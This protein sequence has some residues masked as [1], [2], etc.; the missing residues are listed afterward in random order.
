V[1]VRPIRNIAGHVEFCEVFFDRARTHRSNIVGELNEGWAVSRAVLGFERLRVGAPRI[2][3]RF[4][5]RLIEIARRQD[6]TRDPLFRNKLTQLICDVRD[7]ASLFEKVA[8]AAK[9]GAAPGPEASALKLLATDT[10]QQVSQALVEVLGDAGVLSGVQDFNGYA[11]EALT[12]FLLTR[13]V[14]IYGGTSEVQR[15]IIAKRIL[16]M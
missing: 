7:L 12:P 4:L 16:G 9:T 15:N 6:L 1:T 10:E 8:D 13:A 2:A 14:T 11:T 5:Q 3:T